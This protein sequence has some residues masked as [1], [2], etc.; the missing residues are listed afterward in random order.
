MQTLVGVWKLVEARAFGE[1]G[2]EVPAPLGPNPMGVA[3]FDPTR[4]MAMACD[5]R[6]TL[7]AGIRRAFAAYCGSYTF[8][9]AELVT[10][11]DGA[12]GPDLLED[13][14]SSYPLRHT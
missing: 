5:A 9:G 14:I 7:P 3:I 1:D 2:N 4:S 10:H 13:Q 12:S 6:A 11:V 8:D